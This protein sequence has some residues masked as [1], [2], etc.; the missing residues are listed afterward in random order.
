MVIGPPSPR[1]GRAGEGIGQLGAEHLDGD[2]PVV[3]QIPIAVD[4]RHPAAAKLA[5]EAVAVGEMGREEGGRIAQ[6]VVRWW[7]VLGYRGEMREAS[8]PVGPG[9][10][11]GGQGNPMTLPTPA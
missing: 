4:H 2:R 9:Q 5:I 1:A 11:G 8:N 10:A 3:T 6:R 7:G